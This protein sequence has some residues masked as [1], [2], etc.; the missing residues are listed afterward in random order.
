MIQQFCVHSAEDFSVFAFSISLGIWVW[1][2]TRT[3]YVMIG[4]RPGESLVL[5][6]YTH[7]G[8]VRQQLDVVRR[9]EGGQR[10]MIQEGRAPESLDARDDIVSSLEDWPPFDVILALHLEH[11]I[12]RLVVHLRKQHI[13]NKQKWLV[14]VFFQCI[15]TIND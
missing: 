14:G 3:G 1:L 10:G 7:L 6:F 4:W 5:L 2:V 11:P 15:D 13:T 9:E 12:A 8:D